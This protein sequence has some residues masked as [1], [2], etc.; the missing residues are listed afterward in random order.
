M[1]NRCVAFGS[2]DSMHLRRGEKGLRWTNPKQPE[3]AAGSSREEAERRGLGER[4]A[5]TFTHITWRTC[6]GR[7]DSHSL[8][9]KLSCTH[10]IIKRVKWC[11][12]KAPPTRA[13]GVLFVSRI[14]QRLP[15]NHGGMV[16]YERPL[17]R[18]L[19]QQ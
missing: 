15:S 4:V 11:Q 5:I 14:L 12:K 18:L 9:L 1:Q 10:G 13:G 7:T 19:L 8:E 17:A 16:R 6:R 3:S 2:H